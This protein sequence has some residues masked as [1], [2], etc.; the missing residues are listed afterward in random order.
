MLHINPDRLRPLQS[1]VKSYALP[2]G[3]TDRLSDSGGSAMHGLVM[4]SHVM[5]QPYPMVYGVCTRSYCR[6]E[7]YWVHR[8]GAVTLDEGG[9]RL[10][11]SQNGNGF[12]FLWL[13]CGLMDS[14]QLCVTYLFCRQGTRC[15]QSLIPGVTDRLPVSSLSPRCNHY[16]Y[17]F[18]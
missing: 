18:C 11:E 9:S 3:Q 7:T 1:R 6:Y 4:S 12:F 10:Y 2:A 17:S 15:V 5:D 8:H 13:C 14:R 16:V